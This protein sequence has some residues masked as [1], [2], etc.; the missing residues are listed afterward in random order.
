MA[1]SVSVR[2]CDG[3]FSAGRVTVDVMTT[4]ALAL[5]LAFVVAS[6]WSGI[7]CGSFMRLAADCEDDRPARVTAFARDG[8]ALLDE[9]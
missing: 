4:L 6:F 3:L 9:Q 5:L 8:F 7:W 1:D 2:R